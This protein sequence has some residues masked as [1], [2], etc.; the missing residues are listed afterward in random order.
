MKT[1]NESIKEVA[2]LL[3]KTAHSALMSGAMNQWQDVHCGT[4][5]HT[6]AIAYDAP[7]TYIERELWEATH[8]KYSELC[9]F[10]EEG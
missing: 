5:A 1:L 2:E 7:T 6:L 9:T 8:Q 10:K 3:A 4:A